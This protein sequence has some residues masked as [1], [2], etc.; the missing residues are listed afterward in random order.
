VT[1]GLTGHH[2]RRLNVI[3]YA[4][5]G[6][7]NARIIHGCDHD[8]PDIRTPDH[9]VFI[10]HEVQ[11]QAAAARSLIEERERRKI[12]RL[13][14]QIRQYYVTR[15]ETIKRDFEETNALYPFLFSRAWRELRVE[16]DRP[17]SPG[18]PS[19]SEPLFADV[20]YPLDN[21]LRERVLEIER[22]IINIGQDMV[23]LRVDRGAD[24]VLART[25]GKAVAQARAVLS[26]RDKT[27]Y[28]ARRLSLIRNSLLT[29]WRRVHAQLEG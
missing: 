13:K 6:E 24:D 12:E 7:P 18:A 27:E 3:V 25:C 2:V 19:D 4:N 9:N 5:Y 21:E 20:R 29:T 17:V 1:D 15:S 23:R 26:G 16:R 10:G 28:N 11:E 14:R 8:Y 22:I